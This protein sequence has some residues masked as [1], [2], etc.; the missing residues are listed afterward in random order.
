MPPVPVISKKHSRNKIATCTDILQ[1]VSCFLTCL[2]SDVC[3]CCALL[4]FMCCMLSLEDGV[5]SS[6]ASLWLL[7]LLA[8]PA[9]PQ[10]TRQQIIYAQSSCIMYHVY[11]EDKEDGPNTAHLQQVWHTI[12]NQSASVGRIHWGWAVFFEAV[13][14]KAQDEERGVGP[15]HTPVEKGS[16]NA[17]QQ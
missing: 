7:L 14:P 13:D 1:N 4:H 12:G 15:I 16:S 8:S 17:W 2:T 6:T 9:V 10:R 5:L 3:F 11:E